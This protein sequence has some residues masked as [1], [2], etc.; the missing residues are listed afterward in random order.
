MASRIQHARYV[1]NHRGYAAVV[2]AEPDVGP[3]TV[4]LIGRPKH[5]YLLS[6]STIT[7]LGLGA[8][9]VVAITRVGVLGAP[10]ARTFRFVPRAAYFPRISR[11][12]G[13]PT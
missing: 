11:P 6:E 4:T 1:S 3:Y 5:R 7:P 2:L 10:G 9:G 12:D 13:P 8:N